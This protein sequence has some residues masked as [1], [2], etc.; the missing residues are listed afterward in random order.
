MSS[1]R[2]KAVHQRD[3]SMYSMEVEVQFSELSPH[4]KEM[5]SVDD[6]IMM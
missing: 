6:T 4:V 5:V 3:P 2:R 1:D